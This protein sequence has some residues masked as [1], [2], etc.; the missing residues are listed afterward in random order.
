MKYPVAIRRRMTQIVNS[1]VL[2]EK[3]VLTGFLNIITVKIN[4]YHFW[5][6][7]DAH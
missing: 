6:R 2:I 7:F 3:S 1:K 4:F 5:Y